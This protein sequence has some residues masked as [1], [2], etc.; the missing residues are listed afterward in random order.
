METLKAIIMPFMQ[1]MALACGIWIGIFIERS[2]CQKIIA[3]LVYE[4]IDVVADAAISGGIVNWPSQSPVAVGK[5]PPKVLTPEE[6]FD[7]WLESSKKRL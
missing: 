3:K 2:R 5:L 4:R 7:I 6:Q 1:V